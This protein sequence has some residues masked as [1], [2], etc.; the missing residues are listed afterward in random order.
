MADPVGVES[1]QDEG[2][3]G[4]EVFVPALFNSL[5]D[6]RF[7]AAGRH[8]LTAPMLIGSDKSSLPDRMMSKGWGDFVIRS[9]MVAQHVSIGG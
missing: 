3:V 4:G 7:R 2:Q 8:G 5:L 9:L 1:V 6:Q